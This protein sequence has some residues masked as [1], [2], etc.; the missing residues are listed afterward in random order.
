MEYRRRIAYFA[1]SNARPPHKSFGIYDADRFAHIHIIGKT[2]TGKTTLLETLIRS[3]IAAGH[4][5]A[6]IDPHGDLATRVIAAATKLR[7]DDLV[8]VDPSDPA[9]PYGYNPLAGVSPTWVPLAAS[10]LL[11]ALKKRWSDSWG[12]RMEHVLRNALHA[13]IAAG[14]A[15]LPDILRIGSDEAFRADVL[16][17]VTNAQVRRFWETEYPEYTPSYQRDAFAPIQNKIGALLADPRMERFFVTAPIKLRFRR[18]MDEGKVL[19]VNLARGK[20]GEDSAGLLGAILMTAMSLA[21]FSRADMLEENRRPFFLFIDEFHS[22][23]THSIADMISELRK[24]RVGLTLAHQHMG[25]LDADVRETV[26]G[27]AGTRIVFR[28]GALDAALLAREFAPHFKAEDLLHLPNRN[29]VLTL[30]IDGAPS[31]AFSAETVAPGDA[32]S[33]AR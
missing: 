9:C 10:G 28:V 1:R 20:L 15:S 4:G 30:M 7:P 27:N 23:T 11:E 33:N 8:V 13:L 19:V 17:R 26:L 14:D 6:L 31:P 29:I 16:T 21:A 18:L 5:V 3:D 32:I 24:F 2:G 12:V 22:Y 25:Q